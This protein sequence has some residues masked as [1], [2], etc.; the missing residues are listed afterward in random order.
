MSRLRALQ[1]LLAKHKLLFSTTGIA[2]LVIVAGLLVFAR[3]NKPV[4]AAPGPLEVEVIPVEQTNVPIY[5]EWIGTTEGMVNAEIKAQVTGYL[6]RQAF[7]EGSFVKR[8]ELLFEIDPRPFQA[9]V[10]QAKGQVAQFEGQLEQA[11]S[12]VAQAEAQLTQ[13]NSQLCQAQAQMTQAEANRVKA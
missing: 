13:A 10:D 8:G 9:S 3:S 12:Q 1:S 7:K 4:A 11:T 2:T 5:K 6:V